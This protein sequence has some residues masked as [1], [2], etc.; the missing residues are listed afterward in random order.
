MDSHHIADAFYA[1]KTGQAMLTQLADP[2]DPNTRG[3][4][5][6]SRKQ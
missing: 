3:S 6:L 4:E 5:H 1:S 2:L